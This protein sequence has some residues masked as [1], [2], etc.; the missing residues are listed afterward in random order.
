MGRGWTSRLFGERRS[1]GVKQGEFAFLETARRRERWFKRV[2]ALATVV[3][4]AV[5]ILSFPKGRYAAASIPAEAR[6]ATRW[7]LDLPTPRREIDEAWKRFRQL[8]ILE[9][10]LAHQ[11]MFDEIP[12]DYQKLIRYAGLE[13]GRGLLRWGNYNRTLLLPA[14]VFEPDEM[15]RS[16]RL[17]P[18]TR[19]IWIRNLTLK[20]GV[21]MFFQVPDGPGLAEALHGTS[22]IVVENS[23]TTTNSWG[24]RG[25]E[26][27]RHAPLRGIVLGDSF[28]QGMF[29]DDEHT[30]VEYLRRYL[31]TSLDQKVS[32]LNTGCLG[33]SPEQYHASLLAF[34]KRF[35]PHFV[36]ESIFANDFGDAFEVVQ[37][38]G[39][40]DESRYWLNQ[41][42]EFCRAHELPLLIVAVPFENGMLGR[43]KAGYYPG[44][45]TNILDIGSLSFLDPT[46]DFINAHLELVL[47][48]E[49][50]GKRPYGC[51]LF[52]DPIADGH[53]SPAGSK[54]W[55][56]CVG[57]R[58][59]L[60]LQKQKL[61]G[62][63]GL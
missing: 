60:L 45:I 27:D 29:I 13:P 33:Y 8:S 43:R 37:G 59:V 52:N 15:G 44:W 31:E 53:F 42:A 7:L 25:P 28:M 21:L 19:S 32:L 18:N 20:S 58:L 38:R 61:L 39:E 10:R 6:H 54:A 51:P 36:V 11:K 57:R 2:I 34:A 9:A 50:V 62:M 3:L 14:T 26:P 23:R 1:G 40:W 16:Y 17:R 41:T 35:D 24:L 55:A 56:E 5:V 47:A 4:T 46:D 48:G 49:R 63:R 30:P 12:A 22:G